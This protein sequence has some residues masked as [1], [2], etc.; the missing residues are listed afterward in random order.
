MKSTFRLLK[1][2]C[3]VVLCGGLMHTCRKNDNPPPDDP[4]PLIKVDSLKAD[5]I[6][7]HLQFINAI[8]KQGAIPKGPAGS[9]LKISFEDTLYLNDQIKGPIKFLHEDT[10]QNV[11]GVYLQVHGTFT[12]STNATYYYDIPEI[13]DLTD[14]DTVSVILIGVNPAGLIDPAHGVPQLVF[15]ITIIPYGPGGQPLAQAVRPVKISD[16]KIDPSGN[17]G[18]CGLVL[19]PLGYWDWDLSLVEN[20][21]TG[22]LSF[23]NDPDKVWGGGQF[24]TGCCINGVSSYNTVLNCEKDPAKAQR[25]F[26][27]TFFQH[28]ESATKFFDN[29]TYSQFSRQINVNPDPSNTNFCGVTPGTVIVSSANVTEE[30]TWKITKSATPY[31]GDSLVLSLFQTK[32]NGV[33]LVSPGGFIHQLDCNVLALITPDREGGNSD[34]VSF[35]TRTDPN[36]DGWYDFP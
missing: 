23:Y 35:Y 32:S 15:E 34:L 4:P 22:T 2:S 3:I 18:S 28:I 10:T 14:N 24:I 25:K 33:G 16:P 19:P 8:K 12:G 20:P 5:T 9:S 30:G 21:S 13:P 11:A 7:N 36:I 6:S 27:P 26:F 17:A 29:G 31:K 1:F